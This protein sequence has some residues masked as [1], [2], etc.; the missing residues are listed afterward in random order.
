LFVL[1]DGEAFAD[2]EVDAFVVGALTTPDL[3]LIIYTRPAIRSQLTIFNNSY[4]PK[5]V[6][7]LT[8]ALRH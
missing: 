1:Y 2:P 8:L 4:N 3:S 5:G 6:S 7:H